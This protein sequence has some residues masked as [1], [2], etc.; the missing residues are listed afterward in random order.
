MEENEQINIIGV[1]WID[2][3]LL[4]VGGQNEIALAVHISRCFIV[5][6]WDQKTK[7]AAYDKEGSIFTGKASHTNTGSQREQIHFF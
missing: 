2:S 4:D 3:T 7:H 1:D 6:T 5:V